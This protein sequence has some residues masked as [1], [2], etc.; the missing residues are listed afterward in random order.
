MAADP[1]RGHDCP[2]EMQL[3]TPMATLPDA[4]GLQT[5]A[6]DPVSMSHFE[7]ALESL[8]QSDGNALS[9]IGRAIARDPQFAAG[10]CLRAGALVLGGDSA[11]AASLSASVIAIERNAGANERERRHAAAARHWLDGDVARAA[12]QYGE[13]LRDYPRDRVA[14]LVAHGLDFR[15][16][17]REMLRDRIAMALPHWDIRDPQYGYV[18]S[19]HAFGLEETGDYAAALAE[20]RRSLQLVPDNVSAIHVIAHVLEMKGPPDE[21]IAWLRRTQSIWADNAGFRIHLAWHLALYQLDAD[22]AADALSTYDDLIAPRLSGNSSGLIDAS[23]LLWRLQLRGAG[24]QRRWRW[25]TALWTR[26]RAIGNRAFDLVHAVMALAGSKD[27]ERARQMAKRLKSDT[28]LRAR[29]GSREL[30]I[31]EPLIAAIIAFGRGD[32]GKA[33]TGISA[34]RA[35]ADRCGGSVAQCD[36]IHLTLLEAALRAQRKRLARTLANE[37]ASRRPASRLNR[38][39]KARVR[40][41][42]ASHAIAQP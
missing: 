16:G 2:Q 14:L 40:T 3:V 4:L 18:L 13:L 8:L 23:A 7:R 26:G 35:A 32:Y 19:M 22:A 33:V 37:R 17:R 31:A 38:W 28:M 29:S 36:L 42:G 1:P 34:I 9:L 20:A 39:L 30:Q 15:L 12:D 25:V 11:S 41:L 21:G 24:S 6:V 27:H 10:H 5:S